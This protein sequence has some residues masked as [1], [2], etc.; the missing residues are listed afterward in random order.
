MEIDNN[1]YKLLS[2]IENQEQS[3]FNSCHYVLAQEFGKKWKNNLKLKKLQKAE[4]KPNIP[5]GG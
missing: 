3:K 5:D 1:R 4:S 2:Q